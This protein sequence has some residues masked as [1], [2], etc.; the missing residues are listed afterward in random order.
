MKPDGNF[1][2]D[3][4]LGQILA[5]ATPRTLTAGDAAVYLSLFGARHPLHCAEP[6]AR[7]LGLPGMPIDDWLAFHVVFGKTV[8]DVSL[9]AVANLGY[10]EGRWLAPVFAGDTVTARSEVI[11]LREN[12]NRQSGVVYVRTT[13]SNQ[14][15]EPV[16]SYARW[17]MVH[18][19]DHGA[20]APASA[21]PKLAAAVAVESLICPQLAGYDPTA[22][23]DDRAFEDYAV[24]QRIDHQAGITVEDAEHMMA[25]RLYQNT[26]RLHFDHH[27]AA[28]G[29]F[30]KR[31]IYGGHAISLA[32]A[33]SFNGL[34]NACRVLAL[35]GGRHVA[36]LFA[37]DTVHAW[38]E[39][40]E[41]EPLPGRADAGALRLRQFALKNRDAAGFPG[42]V[43][44][45]YDP[46][47]ILD[48]DLWVAVPRRAAMV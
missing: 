30:G 2:E 37:G 42:A 39:V 38:S 8:P 32:R 31:L 1:F 28:K 11:G 14:R 46:A 43:G 25:T 17:V 47:V 20:P 33:L 35:N 21:V 26:A 44:E 24:G 13:G 10:A 22:T 45:G 41:A 5:H 9:N 23:G 27:A 48:L 40:L 29:R 34:A 15:G 18:K 36:P 12:S 16:L 3:F 6:F 4:S 19:R 7:G